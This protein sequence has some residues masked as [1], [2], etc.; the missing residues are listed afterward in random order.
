MLKFS[1]RHRHGIFFYS[2]LDAI[3]ASGLKFFNDTITA[4]SGLKFKQIQTPS[5]R[6]ALSEATHAL[7]SSR[8]KDAATVSHHE[9]KMPWRCLLRLM[10]MPWWCAMWRREGV[11]WVS[12]RRDGVLWA[13]RDGVQCGCRDGVT[14]ACRDGALRWRPWWRL[15]WTWT[16]R[17]EEG[18]GLGH[19]MNE[20][21]PTEC[22]VW[23]S[24]HMIW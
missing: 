23:S 19:N 8:P 22:T 2:F 14:W 1:L 10:S 4:S 3:T 5:R 21:A 17:T 24:L 15:T 6:L 9:H 11:S 20:Q 16:P 13:C 18:H 12:W 7:C